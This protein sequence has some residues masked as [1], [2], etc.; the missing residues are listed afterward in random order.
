MLLV[1]RSIEVKN[2]FTL[3]LQALREKEKGDWKKMTLEDKKGLYRASFANTFSE[4]G[5]SEGVWKVYIGSIG[6]ALGITI[7]IYCAMVE[8]GELQTLLGY[9]VFDHNREELSV[10]VS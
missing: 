4:I 9:A 6:L 5:A 7:L 8:F 2:V 10:D 3:L 1:I